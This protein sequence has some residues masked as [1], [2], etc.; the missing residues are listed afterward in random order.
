MNTPNEQA[1]KVKTEHIVVVRTVNGRTDTLNLCGSAAMAESAYGVEAGGFSIPRHWAEDNGTP[2]CTR[3]AERL[4]AI[5]ASLNHLA[6]ALRSAAQVAAERYIG[7][8]YTARYDA[9]RVERKVEDVATSLR[10]AAVKVE[11]ALL[12]HRH[13]PDAQLS[14]LVSDVMHEVLWMVPNL[15]L[16][17]AVRD[18][19]AADRRE[20]KMAAL[21]AQAEGGR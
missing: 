9:A 4:G 1:T 3:C 16:D 5:G 12:Y 15:G 14:K 7:E 19:A 13:D 6:G 20:V 17:S 18:A 11:R 10:D 2:W 21:K 8:A